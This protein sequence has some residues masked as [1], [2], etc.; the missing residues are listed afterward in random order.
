MRFK[1]YPCGVPVLALLAVVAQA[2][3]SSRLR[4]HSSNGNVSPDAV[5]RAAEVLDKEARRSGSMALLSLA[6]QASDPDQFQHVKGLIRNMITQH[7]EALNNE[8]DHKAFCDKE[9]SASKSKVKKLTNSQHK[10]KADLDKQKAELAELQDDLSS[11]HDSIAATHKASAEALVRSQEEQAKF[12][13]VKSKYEA[14][15][16]A[17]DSD[18][19]FRQAASEHAGKEL[20]FE[21]SKH[22]NELQLKKMEKDVQYKSSTVIRLKKTIVDS[23]SDLDTTEEQL[24]LAKDYEQQV[25]N[26]CVAKVDPYKERK[27][28]RDAQIS[29]LHDAYQI[30]S[31]DAIP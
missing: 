24:K 2:A 27:A 21:R 16:V 20:E 25:A 23:K 9:S 30:L 3:L 31:G 8:A 7:Y 17:G 26:G 15:H 28:R 1:V 11:L 4:S 18:Q 29:S 6:Q 14:N 22:D 10:G 12:E 19:D 5:A 13:Q